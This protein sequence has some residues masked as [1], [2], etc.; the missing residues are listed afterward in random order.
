MVVLP[1]SPGPSN[2]NL[3]LEEFARLAAASFARDLSIDLE[4]RRACFASMGISSGDVGRPSV[5]V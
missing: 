4:M 5:S 1:L 3:I 2:N